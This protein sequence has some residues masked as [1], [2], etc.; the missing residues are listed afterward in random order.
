MPDRFAARQGH[1]HRRP[2]WSDSRLLHPFRRHAGEAPS[3]PDHVIVRLPRKVTIENAERIGM[4]LQKALD[5]DP[6]VLELDLTR[7]KHLTANGGTAFIMTLR[8]ARRHGTRLIA[9]H[10]GPQV[11]GTLRQL[12]LSCAIDVYEASGP[13][14]A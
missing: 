14:T 11:R 10:A 9:T 7:V 1:E 8:S 5:S 4:N 2:P 13:P 12:G 3:S 6:D